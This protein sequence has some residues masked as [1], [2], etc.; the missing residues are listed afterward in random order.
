MVEVRHTSRN[1]FTLIELSLVV[2]IMA[3]ALVVVVSRLDNVIP[4]SRFLSEANRISSFVEAGFSTAVASGKY[5]SII[6]D[7][8]EQVYFY[9]FPTGE[10]EEDP[11]TMDRS[12]PNPLP[13][14][15]TIEQIAVGKD[16]VTAGTHLFRVSPNGRIKGHLLYLRDDE[17]RK[18]TIEVNALTG[19]TSVYEGYIDPR[20]ELDLEE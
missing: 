14:G 17:G 4:S 9:G 11:A 10:M 15:I 5:V 13:R 3:I 6:Y 7:L 16:I 19:T 12:N 8:N 18:A 1:G 2:A 20:D